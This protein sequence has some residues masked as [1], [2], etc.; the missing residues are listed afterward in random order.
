MC[1][2]AKRKA[3]DGDFDDYDEKTVD[4]ALFA[5]ENEQWNDIVPLAMCSFSLS[6]HQLRIIMRHGA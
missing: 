5:F 4:W 6:L 3:V 1:W 2:N